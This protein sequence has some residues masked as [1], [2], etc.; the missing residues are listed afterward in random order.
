MKNKN[1]ANLPIVMIDVR[2][3]NIAEKF[4]DIFDAA[5]K[6]KRNITTIR[7]Q[8]VNKGLSH[9]SFFVFRFAADCALATEPKHNRKPIVKTT[10]TQT[11]EVKYFDCVEDAAKDAYITK[12]LF[13]QPCKNGLI[14][15]YLKFERLPI[16]GLK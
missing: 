3:W 16:G 6:T 14:A 11:G 4:D 5:K 13:Y 7:S 9:N 8:C 15:G 2:D 10:N 1:W 12:A